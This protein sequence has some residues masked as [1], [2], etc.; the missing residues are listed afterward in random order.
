MH[1][2][3]LDGRLGE[4]RGIMRFG[5]SPDRGAGGLEAPRSPSS[6]PTI[7]WGPGDSLAPVIGKSIDDLSTP[8]VVVD[9]DVL[10]RN[11]ARMAA[12]ARDAGGRLR[13][14]AK[15]HKCP[16]IAPAHPAG[17]AP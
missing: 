7:R 3:A 9:L 11:V 12:S 4:N 15:T 14:H 1:H 16:Q 5:R 13:P 6:V 8:A 2:F 10:E 17:G